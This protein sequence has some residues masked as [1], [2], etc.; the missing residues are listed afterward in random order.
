MRKLALVLLAL[1]GIGCVV[2]GARY[3]LATEFMPYHAVLAGKP[4]AEL[5]PG[6][7]A[8]VLGMMKIMG[9]AIAACGLALLA[10][11][12]AGN[13]GAR[14]PAVAAAV[15]GSV[16]GAPTLYV[17]L[18]L[19]TVNPRAETPVALTAVLLVLILGSSL[20]LWLANGRERGAHTAGGGQAQP[21]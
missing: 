6:V 20:L 1:S 16:V 4:W 5:E 7:Q 11:A 12:W 9:S 14:W 3:A 13:A 2:V 8:I 17:T 18:F 21:A 15:V 10:F 19:R